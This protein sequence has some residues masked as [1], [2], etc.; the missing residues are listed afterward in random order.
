LA[1]LLIVS[2]FLALK[3]KYY[4][5]AA[6]LAGL[7]VSTRSTGVILLPVL[8]WEMWANRD[9]TKFLLALL[10]CVL[11]ATSGFWL[12]MVYLWSAFGT[13]FAFADGQA[14]LIFPR[15]SGRV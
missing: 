8:L 1:L 14:A 7:A 10:P 4:L 6:L 2:F 9:Q 12:F 13:P 11:L 15:K 5:S 3:R